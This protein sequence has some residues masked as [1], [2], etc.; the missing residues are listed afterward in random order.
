MAAAPIAVD[1]DVGTATESQ[2]INEVSLPFLTT[3]HS[4]QTTVSRDAANDGVGVQDLEEEVRS[5]DTLFNV[6]DCS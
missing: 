2:I 3:G 5:F 6:A 1:E 4:S